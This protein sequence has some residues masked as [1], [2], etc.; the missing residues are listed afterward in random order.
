MRTAIPVTGAAGWAR[1]R[2]LPGRRPQAKPGLTQ[3]GTTILRSAST[4]SVGARPSTWI[5]M[6]KLIH[7]RGWWRMYCNAL[8]PPSLSSRQ[9]GQP[10]HRLYA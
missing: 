3:Q 6:A 7:K 5:E 2:E 4:C 1:G 10:S 8:S 9:L